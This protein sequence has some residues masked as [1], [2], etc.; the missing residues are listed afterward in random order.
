MDLSAPRTSH[1]LTLT[2]APHRRRKV[3][4]LS[5]ITR[6]G[7]CSGRV[8]GSYP[9][10]RWNNNHARQ[11]HILFG[12]HGC[13]REERAI[14]DAQIISGERSFRDVS[15]ET[16]SSLNLPFEYSLKIIKKNLDLDSDFKSFHKF[17]IERYPIYRYL[18]WSETF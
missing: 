12:C 9:G 7:A 2:L 18:C 1:A 17:C 16:W 13:G 3:I 15:E 5:G 4:C 14:L 6:P 8:D 10:L 11:R